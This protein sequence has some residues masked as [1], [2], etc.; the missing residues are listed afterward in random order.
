MYNIMQTCKVIKTYHE[1][2]HPV[3][4]AVLEVVGWNIAR[5]TDR[6]EVAG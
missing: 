1:V 6:K 2:E 3:E 4:V 5:Q